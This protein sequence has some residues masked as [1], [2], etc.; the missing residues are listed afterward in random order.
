VPKNARCDVALTRQ[1]IPPQLRDTLVVVIDVLRATTTIAYA[2]HNGARSVM[3]CE[4]PKDALALRERLGEQCVL[5]GERDAVRIAGFDLDNSPASYSPER[6]AGRI[7]AFTTTNGTRALRRA[8]EAGAPDILCAA[9][10]NLNAIVKRL[11]EAPLRNVLLACAGSEGR[12]ALED[13]LLAGALA[14]RLGESPGFELSDAA[15]TA[16]LAYRAAAPTL[17]AGIASSEHAQALVRAGFANDIAL[18]ARI[19]SADVLAMLR[20]GEVVKG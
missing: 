6:I 7:V 2:L 8:I 15:K 13:V 19:D 4:E 5:G 11:L 12:V 10:A 16:A 20:D 9:F 18:A 1:E 3:P 14:Q 17:A